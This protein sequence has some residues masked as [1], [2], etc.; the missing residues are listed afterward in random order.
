[1]HSSTL[2]L[3]SGLDGSGWST[4]SPG[5]FT[6]EKDPVPIAYEVG[7]APGPVST[8]AKNLAPTGIRPPDRPEGSIEKEF[9]E[10]GC[11]CRN[12]SH[13]TQNRF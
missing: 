7:W 5:R 6:P 13:L 1:M 12:T 2:S 8:G 11:E 3:I 4:L 9:K 10:A